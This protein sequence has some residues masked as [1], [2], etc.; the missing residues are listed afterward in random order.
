[1]AERATYL[2]GPTFATELAKGEPAAIVLAGRDE[3]PLQAAQEALSHDNFWVYSTGDVRGV[4]VGGAL[5]NVVA[6]AAGMSDGLGYGSN[7]RAAVITRGL[8]EI[9][10]FGEAMGADAQTFAGLSGMGD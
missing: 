7:A 5:K 8:A 10:R 4:L 2:S 1:I 3:A 9:T 6:I